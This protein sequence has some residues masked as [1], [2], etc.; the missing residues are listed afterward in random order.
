MTPFWQCHLPSWYLAFLAFWLNNW[1]VS[2]SLQLLERRYLTVTQW[3]SVAFRPSKPLHLKHW[4]I[5]VLIR[6]YSD[7]Y[8][9][10][11]IHNLEVLSNSTISSL[12]FLLDF[13][14]VK[15][16]VF[17]YILVL[18][19]MKNFSALNIFFLCLPTF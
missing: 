6:V 12:Y 4:T 14:L 9:T 11:F 5:Y 8:C 13:S 1:T 15:W 2:Q 19:P 18:V 16:I 10:L 17:T 7:Q 3:N